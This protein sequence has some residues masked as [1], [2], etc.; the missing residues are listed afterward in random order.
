M[1]WL[2]TGILVLNPEFII[3]GRSGLSEPFYLL[4]H[5]ILFSLLYKAWF[6]GKAFSNRDIILLAVLSL[7]LLFIR[8]EGILYIPVILYSI[9]KRRFLFTNKN[10]KSSRTIFL[11]GIIY[12]FVLLIVLIP[13]GNWVKAKSGRFNIAPKITFNARIGT[14]A[15]LLSQRHGLDFHNP[16]LMEELSWYGLDKNTNELYSKH[17]F[18]DSYYNSLVTQLH[19]KKKVWIKFFSLVLTNIEETARMLIRSNPFPLFFVL[20]IF[21]G[22]FY[23]FKQNKKLLIFIV[24][25]IF[26]SVYFLISHVQERFFYVMLPYLSFLAAYGVYSVALKIKRPYMLYNMVLL[27]LFLNAS[28]YY[29]AYYQTLQKNEVYYQVGQDLKQTI[30]GEAKVCV[31]NFQPT[32]FSGNAF[33][34]MPYCSVS[35]LHLYLQKNNTSYLLLGEEVDTFRKEF[36]P[37]FTR[38]Q[39]GGF[40]WIKTYSNPYQVF[41][42]FKVIPSGA[43]SQ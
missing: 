22:L 32:F 2:A 24:I 33:L 43:A 37:I 28:L 12:L 29:N 21:T 30:P 41:K 16:D 31:K 23:L 35:D 4:I 15:R 26:P 34:K 39:T 40:Q 5:L 7:F 17:I 14:V 6:E 25:W 11:A 8:S 36:K 38:Q 19:G 9:L 3:L 18:D 13:Y 1:A 27:L 42:L 10:T 20:L